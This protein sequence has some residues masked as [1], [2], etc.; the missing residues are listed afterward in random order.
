MSEKER[1]L[2]GPAKTQMMSNLKNTVWGWK[3]LI[4]CRYRDQQVQS[5]TSL[6]PYELAEA[7]DGSAAIRV[8][9]S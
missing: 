4:G 9:A 6:L 8:G 3:K 5:Q 1:F 7:P 2:G